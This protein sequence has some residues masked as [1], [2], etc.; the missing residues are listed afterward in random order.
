[1]GLVMAVVVAG[2]V[3]GASVF[4]LSVT[5]PVASRIHAFALH[6]LSSLN[7]LS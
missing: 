4:L 3:R 2:C 5:L 6:H 7:R 1:M